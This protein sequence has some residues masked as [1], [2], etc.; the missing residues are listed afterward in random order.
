MTCSKT[1]NKINLQRNLYKTAAG[2]NFFWKPLVQLD[3]KER[4]ITKKALD[5]AGEYV[6]KI[7][8]ED[9]VQWKL[10]SHRSYH[11]KRCFGDDFFQQIFDKEP[12]RILQCLWLDKMRYPPSNYDSQNLQLC[13]IHRLAWKRSMATHPVM[14][15]YV[16]EV[17]GTMGQF[18]RLRLNIIPLQ[19]D[20]GG[21]LHRCE[22]LLRGLVT[23]LFPSMKYMRVCVEYSVTQSEELEVD[24]VPHYS[25]MPEELERLKKEDSTDHQ[26]HFYFALDGG[27]TLK[28]HQIW[29]PKGGKPS[30]KEIKLN[31]GDI[32]FFMSNVCLSSRRESNR[33][34]LCIKGVLSDTRE[35]CK[36]GY[37]PKSVAIEEELVQRFFTKVENAQL[38]VMESQNE[39]DGNIKK[40]ELMDSFSRRIYLKK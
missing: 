23:Q 8:G 4:E 26:I 15:E 32:F 17:P 14:R 25:I 37:A 21:S 3:E 28:F 13:Q 29:S 16:E 38:S 31:Q 11:V 35:D 27:K 40:E 12:D 34:N 1:L 7:C 33:R 20:P 9:K 24:F 39:E 6:A 5:E 18:S 30:T 36:F 19:D 2:T 10:E 22:V